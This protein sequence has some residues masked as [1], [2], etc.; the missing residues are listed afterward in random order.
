[1]PTKAL[2]AASLGALSQIPA[3][4]TAVGLQAGSRLFVPWCSAWDKHRHTQI[5]TVTMP[6]N[7]TSDYVTHTGCTALWYQLEGG[8]KFCRLFNCAAPVFFRAKI[9][10]IAIFALKKTG[11]SQSKHRHNFHPPSSWYHRTVYPTFSQLRSPHF[12][13][14]KVYRPKGGRISSESTAAMGV[15]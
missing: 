3:T 10:E 7:T 15:T 12:T 1:M 13:T 5:T 9:S 6:T 8:W 4:W 14:H 2:P 11:A